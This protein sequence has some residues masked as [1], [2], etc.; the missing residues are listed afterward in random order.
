MAQISPNIGVPTVSP[1]ATP[2]NDYQNV[3]A[4]PEQTGGLIAQGLDRFGAGAT[5]AGDFFGEVQTDDASN[6]YQKAASELTEHFKTLNGAD[7]LNAQEDTKKQLDDLYRAARSGLAR[8]DQQLKFDSQNRPYTDRYI[9]GQ[10]S[11][12]AVQQGQTF[13]LKTNAD[14]TDVAHN[15]AATAGSMGDEKTLAVARAKALDAQ[16]KTLQTM[17]Q[18]NDPNAQATAISKANLVYKTYAETMAASGPQGALKAQQFLE[19]PEI[20]KAL[21]DNYAEVYSRTRAQADQAKA[22]NLAS[23]PLAAGSIGNPVTHAYNVATGKFDLPEGAGQGGKPGDTVPPP[24][25]DASGNPIPQQASFT[26]AVGGD[27]ASLIRHFENPAGPW[28]NAHWDVNHWRVGYSSDTVT[29]ADGSVAPVTATTV[30]TKEDAERDLQRRVGQSQQQIQSSIGQEAWSK[31]SPQ[32]QASLTSVTYNYG[33]L[34]NELIGPAQSGDQSALA[35]AIHNLS[36]NPDRRRQEAAN[37]V[38]KF[39]LGGPTATRTMQP[40]MTLPSGAGVP[41]GVQSE[42]ATPENPVPDVQPAVATTDA[43]MQPV[44]P[45]SPEDTATAIRAA[46]VRMIEE[47]DASPEVKQRAVA[48][49]NEVFQAAMI[50]AQ[51]DKKAKDEQNNQAANDYTTEMMK[52]PSPDIVGRIANDKRIT[53]FETRKA[54]WDLALK[55]SGENNPAVYGKGFNDVYQRIVKSP[56]DP[57][58]ISDPTEI[59]KMGAGDTPAL[60]FAGTQKALTILNESRKSVDGAG[61]NVT[62]AGAYA[63]AKKYLSFESDDGFL[64]IHDVEGEK[65]FNGKF[66]KMFESAF[67]DWTVKQGK[68]PYDFPLFDD[69]KMDEFLQKI[70]PKSER[71]AARLSAMGDTIQPPAGAPQPL[72]PTPVDADSYGWSSIVSKPPMSNGQPWK[73]SD[74]AGAINKLRADPSPENAAKFDRYFGQSGYTAEQI[75]SRTEKKTD[76]TPNREPVVR[77]P[78]VTSLPGLL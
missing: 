56:G 32:A 49:V 67:D 76:T 64:K 27:S 66:T 35:Q 59:L 7:A 71:D 74:W 70:R 14:A 19:R 29:R 18:E 45:P 25:Y 16:A 8:P 44:A 52:G 46:R 51:V 33:H 15:M 5:K 72:P 28:T 20:V 77:Q 55:S 42:V 24:K 2:G 26:S 53:S 54:L 41:S 65:L 50:A 40:T 34:P 31:L 60:T 12:H 68:N 10:I 1:D 37:V 57:D 30:V 75:L 38:G 63:N 58:R 73:L 69:K 22:D 48:K 3:R 61:L 21:G 47:A 62:K 17:G 43:A 11:T 6:N 39:G 23:A 9:L 36:S 78:D 4:T 13:A